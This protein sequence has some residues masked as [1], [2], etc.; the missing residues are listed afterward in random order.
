MPK[1]FYVW[2][3]FEGAMRLT[4]I[5]HDE[6]EALAMAIHPSNSLRWEVDNETFMVTDHP[7]EV[8]EAE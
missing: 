7:M 6:E 8:E 2:Q 3:H 4:V 5:A 1:T